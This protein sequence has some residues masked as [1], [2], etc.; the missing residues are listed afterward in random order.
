[1]SHAAGLFGQII[2]YDQPWVGNAIQIV[3][4]GWIRP[5]T[6]CMGSTLVLQ[7]SNTNPSVNSSNCRIRGW[8]WRGE[9]C[10]WKRE[11]FVSNHYKTYVYLFK[12]LFRELHKY[13]SLRLISDSAGAILIPGPF[14]LM[15]FFVTLHTDWSTGTDSIQEHE[16]HNRYDVSIEHF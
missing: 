6:S 1:M 8:W 15:I 13:L 12:L 3:G 16:Q 11:I 9:K 14:F 2:G 5:K 7:R 10:K 4:M